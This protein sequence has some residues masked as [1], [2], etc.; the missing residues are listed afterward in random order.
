[1]VGH[2]DVLLCFLNREFCLPGSSS[3]EGCGLTLRLSF[4]V[5]CSSDDDVLFDSTPG[6]DG[7]VGA[8]FRKSGRLT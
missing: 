4:V 7:V 1:M 5:G 8:V 3:F 6:L 2:R